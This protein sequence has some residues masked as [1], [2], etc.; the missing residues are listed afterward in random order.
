MS[1]KQIGKNENNNSDPIHQLYDE[2][3]KKLEDLKKMEKK[4]T[5]SEEEEEEESSYSD[6]H[7]SGLNS[8]SKHNNSDQIEELE[9]EKKAS[10]LS[11]K[12]PKIE[13]D[14]QSKEKKEEANLS[15]ALKGEVKK[16]GTDEYYHV[17]TNKI[18]FSIYNFGTGF[19][20]VLKDPKYKISEIVKQMNS[21]KEKLKVMNSKFLAGIKIREKKKGPAV[22]KA[23]L[24]DEE[25][26]IYSEKKIKLMEIQ[27]ALASKEKQKTIINL[28]I[29][30]FV[31]FILVI[32]S[33]VTSILINN[34]LLN[35]TLIYY[36]LIEKSVTLYRNLIFEI[37]FVREQILLAN[38]LY[39]NTY[40]KDKNLYYKDFASACYDYY[41]DTAF[42]LSNLST[43]INT[44]SAENKEKIVGAK[45]E[46]EI[47]DAI[48]SHDGD[49]K[50]K[51]YQLKI[52]SAFNELNSALY[53]VSQMKMNEINSYEDNVY[54]FTRNA[55]N[56]MLVLASEQIDNF[57]DEF[58]GEI[59]K[60]Q[61]V[62]FICMAVMFVVYAINYFIFIFFYEKVEERKQ[63]YL[64]VFY[65]IGSGFIINSLAKCEKF[66]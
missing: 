8:S 44:L 40:D 28:C 37:N 46:L 50:T 64:A 4:D 61:T 47:I 21:E 41:L 48:K 35:R 49:Y 31:V 32:G 27:K 58:Y 15:N 54:Y 24:D 56:H 25:L 30:S 43:T 12:L 65:E 38:S 60:G 55:M 22:K 14:A 42:V 20:E 1:Y 33:S 13:N 59:K 5:N 3:V 16:D 2:A 39:T 57:T 51:P 17:N 53:H 45:G 18:T 23:V 9:I 11:I 34:Y 29:F 36:N 19:V 7:S 63:S 62:L 6:T 66:L 52:Y 10:R 26:D